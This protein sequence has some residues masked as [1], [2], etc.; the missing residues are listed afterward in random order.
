[1]QPTLVVHADWGTASHKRWMACAVWRP[2]QDAQRLGLREDSIDVGGPLDAQRLDPVG[3]RELHE[4]RVALEVDAGQA[5][6][7]DDFLGSGRV[8]SHVLELQVVLVVLQVRRLGEGGQRHLVLE[9]PVDE[10]EPLAG[11][12]VAAAGGN[13]LQ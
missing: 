4:V 7:V 2:A 5:V 10:A 3:L 9:D 11:P 1:M 12:Q 13:P 6:A 8:N